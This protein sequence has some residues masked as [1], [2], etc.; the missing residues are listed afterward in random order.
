MGAGTGGGN[1]AAD[2]TLIRANQGKKRDM[3]LDAIASMAAHHQSAV[4]K[5]QDRGYREAA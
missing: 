2:A 4:R 3:M 1:K 5:Q